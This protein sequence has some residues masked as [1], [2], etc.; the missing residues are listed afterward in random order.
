MNGK[1][2]NTKGLSELLNIHPK[3]AEK[4][5]RKQIIPGGFQINGRWFINMESVEKW[6]D[7]RR[8]EYS[9]GKFVGGKNKVAHRIVNGRILLG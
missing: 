2:L 4:Y 7:A 9:K 3:T 1:R 5:L 8:S 6:E